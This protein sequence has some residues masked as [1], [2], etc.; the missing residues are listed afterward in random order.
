[1]QVATV[2][3]STNNT[4]SCVLPRRIVVA[5][6]VSYYACY[7][8]H[9]NIL[10]V[11]LAS[12]EPPNRLSSLAFSQLLQTTDQSSADEVQHVAMQ[13]TIPDTPSRSL[14][15][16]G[17]KRSLVSPLARSG[18]TPG[19]VSQMQRIFQDAKASLKF[20]A[21]IASSPTGSITSRLPGVPAN[22]VGRHHRHTIGYNA[23]D[24]RYST[25]PPGLAE[26]ELD[27]R[28][29]FP[30]E[31]PG[32]PEHDLT[33]RKHIRAVAQEPMSSGFTSPVPA[34]LNNAVMES[35]T[36]LHAVPASS[37]T[38]SDQATVSPLA[39]SG[40]R[41]DLACGTTSTELEQPMRKMHVNHVD[42]WLHGVLQNSPNEQQEKRIRSTVDEARVSDV[43]DVA[44]VEMN[45]TMFPQEIILSTPA[46]AAAESAKLK[47]DLLG[48][49]IRAYSE[50]ENAGPESRDASN[51]LR[52]TT[53]TA[54]LLSV[55][56]VQITPSPDFPH[57]S[58]PPTPIQQVEL[59]SAPPFRRVDSTGSPFP[60]LK[61]KLTNPADM[62]ASY[63][64]WQDCYSPPP[65][66]QFASP[67]QEAQMSPPYRQH[68]ATT[69]H[70]PQEYHTGPPAS[71][72]Y[73][74]TETPLNHNK[75]PPAAAPRSQQLIYLHGPP[76]HPT[77]TA[78][79][80]S[81]TADRPHYSFSTAAA[82]HSGS[83]AAPD[84]RIRDAYRT[85]T[86]TPFE[87]PTTRFR[88]IGLG[89]AAQV[90][91]ATQRNAFD[92]SA[93]RATRPTPS[94]ALTASGRPPSVNDPRMGLSRASTAGA[95]KYYAHM[96]RRV[97]GGSKS[98]EEVLFRSSPP[99][100]AG[101]FHTAPRRK[102]IRRSLSR[103]DGLSPTREEEGFGSNESS[104]GFKFHK[105]MD[106][107]LQDDEGGCAREIPE[108]DGK[109]TIFR[110]KTQLGED[111]VEGSSSIN[112]ACGTERMLVSKSNVTVE[113]HIEIL[114]MPYHERPTDQREGEEEEEQGIR[115]LSPYV[116]P[117]RK[118][119]GPKL[120]NQ[121]R[122]PSYW[123]EDILPTGGLITGQ[124]GERGGGM[125]RN[126]AGHGSRAKNEEI[127]A[128]GEEKENWDPESGLDGDQID[129]N[130]RDSHGVE[131]MEVDE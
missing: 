37:S 90:K 112:E 76:L 48:T 85:D 49:G 100:P 115:E 4:R 107:D 119:K 7:R 118:G 28:E 52:C 51:A 94:R 84:S 86:L 104:K 105:D 125:R 34:E 124:R 53:P 123:D 81:P 95:R 72:H 122:R 31:S 78:A 35:T 60:I 29:P 129:G 64:Q 62:M 87:M 41:P 116:S 114:S 27:V 73:S 23:T 39:S 66:Q 127:A 44:D 46:K 10:A 70:S 54:N 9:A 1:M 6:S 17:R 93:T 47:R 21:A 22:T 13:P 40:H 59:P 110:D 92:N 75:P 45:I 80:H 111:A 63:T 58:P 102:R 79:A 38:K 61:E 97:I 89:A 50:K 12:I 113:D 130:G 128:G 2:R 77:P 74:I 126:G 131:R 33:E 120:C 69:H 56:T 98:P 67:P 91:G 88:K 5:K 15:N 24:W 42:A 121:E 96:Q 101:H 65:H 83:S 68:Y 18:A 19:Y 8:I 11:P 55:P 32:L 57:G 108:Q 3:F 20:D 99:R 16:I 36:S 25:M 109:M 30:V 103:G 26:A 14:S 71:Q 117:Y 82:A 43:H 106:M